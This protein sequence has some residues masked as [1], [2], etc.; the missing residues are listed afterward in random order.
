MINHPGVHMLNNGQF[1]NYSNDF[2]RNTDKHDSDEIPHSSDRSLLGIQCCSDD[3]P[4]WDGSLLVGHQ[5]VTNIEC[6][7]KSLDDNMGTD[8]DPRDT[9][10]Y[11]MSDDQFT[12]H[13]ILLYRS[14]KIRAFFGDDILLFSFFKCDDYILAAVNI[15]P[16]GGY[17]LIFWSIGDVDSEIVYVSCTGECCFKQCVGVRPIVYQSRKE[18]IDNIIGKARFEIM[19]EV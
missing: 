1:P 18:M 4:M 15:T 3:D 16:D 8:F 14:S 19:P 9:C 6:L 13:S 17:E 12:N 2:I 5:E 11:L 10:T 7:E